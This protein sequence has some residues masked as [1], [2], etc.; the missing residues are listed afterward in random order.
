MALTSWHRRLQHSWV[1]L[2]NASLRRPMMNSSSTPR[3]TRE[4]RI[5][6]ADRSIPSS[7]FATAPKASRNISFRFYGSFSSTQ[8]LLISALQLRRRMIGATATCSC[9]I[10]FLS[11]G[12]PAALD[13]LPSLRSSEFT[14]LSMGPLAC[15]SQALSVSLLIQCSCSL[16]QESNVRSSFRGET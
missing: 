12:A 10:S 13:P 8:I 7:V 3:S 4:A 1:D 5:F 9:A 6:V 15:I 2:P 14:S 16:P 11:K